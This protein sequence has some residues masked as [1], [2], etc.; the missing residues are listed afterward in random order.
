MI[1]LKFQ[2]FVEIFSNRIAKTVFGKL[3]SESARLMGTQWEMNRVDGWMDV[4]RSAWEMKPVF[5]LLF[6]GLLFW[7]KVAEK[8]S[9]PASRI[10]VKS[11]GADDESHSTVSFQKNTT[12]PTHLVESKYH[13]DVASGPYSVNMIN[14]AMIMP[15]LFSAIIDTI[16]CSRKEKTEVASNIG[17]GLMVAGF[18]AVVVGLSLIGISFY[19]AAFPFLWNKFWI[20]YDNGY[21]WWILAL[22]DEYNEIF[23][24]DFCDFIC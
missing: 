13:K 20:N 12:N 21:L 6:Y 1:D 5:S 23:C 2:K 18:V 16:I 11:F 4:S 8:I 10:F 24:I 9:W 19:Q 17:I 7:R 22:I 15:F 3:I 14:L